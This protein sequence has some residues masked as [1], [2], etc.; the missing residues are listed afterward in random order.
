MTTTA[1]SSCWSTTKT[2]TASGPR[3]SMCRPAGGWYSATAA[4]RIALPMS[5]STGRTCGRAVFAWRWLAMSACAKSNWLAMSACAKSNWLG[6][7][8]RCYRW[9]LRPRMD[10]RLGLLRY[11][12][13]H[14]EHPRVQH[15]PISQCRPHRAVQ[16]VLQVD[17]APPFDRVWEEVS[18]ERGVLRQQP[19]QCDHGRGRDQLVEADLP[20]RNLGPLPLGQAVVRVGLAVADSL[21]DHRGD[22]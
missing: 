15:R 18:V 6:I 22:L 19:V 14:V 12:H 8:A 11:W 3:S 5:T 2:S 10:R 9:V 17:D 16:T 20:W 4:A 1:R 7:K 21:E 13:V